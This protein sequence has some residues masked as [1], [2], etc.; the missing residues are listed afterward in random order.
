[1]KAVSA[2]VFVT[3]APQERGEGAGIHQFGPDVTQP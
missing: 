2:S 1:M 3:L